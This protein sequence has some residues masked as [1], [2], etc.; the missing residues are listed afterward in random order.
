M[1]YTKDGRKVLNLQYVAL[2]SCGNEVTYP[3]KG[4]I[5]IKEKPLKLEYCIWSKEGKVDVVWGEQANK[6]LVMTSDVI[7]LQK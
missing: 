3:Y 7:G 2:N 6:D 4:S 1:Y 5:V